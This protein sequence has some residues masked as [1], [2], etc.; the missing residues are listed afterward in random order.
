M[1][2]V[3]ECPAPV[4]FHFYS[5]S[6]NHRSLK[7]ISANSIT[8]L[9]FGLLDFKTLEGKGS[10]SLRKHHILL[11]C[12]FAIRPWHLIRGLNILAGWKNLSCHKMNISLHGKDNNSEQLNCKKAA[13]GASQSLH[14]VYHH[15]LSST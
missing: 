14:E 13:Y 2:D 15:F 5:A 7:L 10:A 4:I 3:F 9:I 6:N 8:S 1:I 12:Y 11:F